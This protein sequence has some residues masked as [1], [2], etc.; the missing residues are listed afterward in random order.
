MSSPS[1]NWL[2]FPSDREHTTYQSN[3]LHLWTIL[4][5]N[6]WK[7]FSAFK[8]LGNFFPSFAVTTL[9]LLQYLNRKMMPFYWHS[10]L[11]QEEWCQLLEANVSINVKSKGQR[12]RTEC[13]GGTVV[14]NLPAR[15]GDTRAVNSTPGLGRSPGKKWQPTLVFKPKEFHEHGRLEGYGPWG[16]KVRHNWA[17]MYASRL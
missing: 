8:I 3:L 10:S 9:I 12:F 15:A 14:K 2:V 17:S 11:P 5:E 6:S 16:L 4:A 1:S 13:P 7:N